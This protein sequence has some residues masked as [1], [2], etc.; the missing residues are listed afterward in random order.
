MLPLPDPGRDPPPDH[1]RPSREGAQP[2]EA[3]A[4]AE[5]SPP[6]ATACASGWSSRRGRLTGLG[7]TLM[8]RWAP[9][10]ISTGTGLLAGERVPVD[11]GALEHGERPA[12]RYAE[13]TR[14][15]SLIDDAVSVTE[16]RR[17]TRREDLPPGRV[18]GMARRSAGPR[19]PRDGTVDAFPVRRRPR[20]RTLRGDARPPTACPGSSSRR[21]RSAGTLPPTVTGCSSTARRRRGRSSSATFVFVGGGDLRADHGASAGRSRRG[22]SARA[23]P[24]P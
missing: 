8:P 22:E 7:V 16:G 17:S 5:P 4:L 18:A 21:L 15:G 9:A 20:L 3:A 12:G 23:S 2:E 1:R 10:S 14:R 6:A 13:L 19:L 11:A 24:S